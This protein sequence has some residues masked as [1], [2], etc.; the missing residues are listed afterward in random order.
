LFGSVRDPSGSG[1]MRRKPIG[2]FARGNNLQSS[3]RDVPA[4][5]VNVRRALCVR[6]RAASLPS[7]VAGLTRG[8]CRCLAPCHRSVYLDAN[9]ETPN[10]M[11]QGSL[12]LPPPTRAP[13]LKQ[14]DRHPAVVSWV[15]PSVNGGGACR[16]QNQHTC[17]AS[18]LVDLVRVN[19]SR[20][21]QVSSVRV[22]LATPLYYTIKTRIRTFLGQNPRIRKSA[23]PRPPFQNPPH[24]GRR[25]V[26][27]VA[28][29]TP[30]G[31]AAR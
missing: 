27:S 24:Q 2:N 6:A 12:H 16:A 20:Q 11:R 21:S 23:A 5:A 4:T 31:A 26:F 18:R 15:V 9:K 19:E 13:P 8:C 30:R 14:A 25:R 28:T 7:W 10:G 22:H 3:R 1:T 29:C 17:K